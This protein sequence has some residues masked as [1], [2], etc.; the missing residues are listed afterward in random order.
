MTR[1]SRVYAHIMPQIIADLERKNDQ[2]IENFNII[3]EALTYFRFDPP[4]QP[5]PKA[6]GKRK[7]QAK[8]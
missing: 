8:E 5:L 7:A 3:N 2:R 4:I 6:T 1:L